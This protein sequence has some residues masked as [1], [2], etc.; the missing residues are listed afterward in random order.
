MIDAPALLQF[1][2][3][4]EARSLDTK[5]NEERQ[6]ALEFY[7]GDLFGN[8]VP[9]RSQV[10]TRDVAETID[11]MLASILRTMVSG[12]RVVEFEPSTPGQEDIAS[13]ITDRV[14]WNFLREQDGYAI[15]RDGIKAGLLEKSGVFKSWV[16]RPKVPQPQ[17]IN[18][19]DIERLG[20][21]VVQAQPVDDMIDLDEAT[22]EP[23]Q[24]Y[25][26]VA[27][28][29]GKAKFRDAAIPNEEFFVAPDARTLDTAI[30]LGNIS[31]VS[32]SELIGMGYPLEDVENLWGDS[33]TGKQLTD[34]R[35]ANRIEREENVTR[36]DLG[37]V[38]T[39][40]EE[41]ARVMWEGRYQL[42]R[43]HRVGTSILSVEPV[44]MQPYSLWCPFPMQHRLIGQSLADKVMDLQLAR[45]TALRQYMDAQNIANAP[46]MLVSTQGLSDTTIDD[47]LDVAPGGLV[48]YDGTVPPQP[49]VQP[50]TASAAMEALQFLAGEKEARTGITRLN[51]GL[52]ADA[53]NKTATGTALMQASGQQMEELVAREAAN[54]VAEM[55]EKKLKLMRA[56]ME[57]H[58]F[59]TDGEVVEMD[60]QQWPED[61]RLA[62]RVGLGSGNKDRKLQG[63]GFLKQ[64]QAEAIQV[65]PRLVP[66][67]KAYATAKLTASVLGFGPATQFFAD[68]KEFEKQPEQPDPA[69]IEA[70][71]KAQQAVAELQAKAQAEQQRFSLDQWKAQQDAQLA[72]EK[73]EAEMALARERMAAEFALKRDQMMM[74]ASVNASM[75][76]DRPG[77]SLA[78]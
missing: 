43:V 11:Y 57:P 69:V 7:R 64:T 52:D 72:R 60:P 28:V 75:A 25:D 44:D 78:Q 20:A 54:G 63:I 31:R 33:G 41:Y 8:E 10:R 34:A 35:D 18:T 4:E 19:L 13:Q 67:E 2:Q 3:A 30:Y 56:E 1:L 68:P 66:A 37:R 38:V 48:R 24:V 27:M 51:Q 71:A 45:S 26:A 55:F 6:T 76:Q 12:D 22:G 65:D 5:L 15:L 70:Q 53:L 50:F 47:L 73:A 77:G 42:I 21:D 39:L 36:A 23:I 46:R 17:R 58:Q 49:L 40:R 14:H 59:S 61:L 62:V 74:Q 9:G 29:P 32:L 16:E